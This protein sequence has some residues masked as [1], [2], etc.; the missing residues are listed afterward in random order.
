M[1]P[2]DLLYFQ[3]KVRKETQ[4]EEIV[5]APED[6]IYVYGLFIEGARWSEEESV[7][8][9]QNPGEMTFPMPIIHFLPVKKK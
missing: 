1:E 6:G 5:H 9:E 8:E 4:P 7:L 2:I 3:F